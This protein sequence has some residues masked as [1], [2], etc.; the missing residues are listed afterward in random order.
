VRGRKLDIPEIV[1]RFENMNGVDAGQRILD[2]LARDPYGLAISN[3]HY[4]RSEVRPLQ[5]IVD[6]KRVQATRESVAMQEYPLS[7]K[8][9]LIADPARLT[10]SARDFLNYVASQEGQG[11]VLKAGDYLPLPE[12]VLKSDRAQI[13]HQR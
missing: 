6:G 13:A 9:F 4:A 3:V 11:D 7:R 5:L 2:A 10:S 1:T 8:V 12:A